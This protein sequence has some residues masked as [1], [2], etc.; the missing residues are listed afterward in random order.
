MSGFQCNIFL[1]DKVVDLVVG[2][3]VINGAR[4]VLN[5]LCLSAASE[6]LGADYLTHL[7]S[8]YLYISCSHILVFLF[9]N[10]A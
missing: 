6:L 9:L 7:F 5:D 2:G 3:S 4:L 8:L 10:T 1:V